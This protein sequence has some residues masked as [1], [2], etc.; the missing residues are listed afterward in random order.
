[1]ALSNKALKLTKGGTAI[2]NG[3][4]CALR[5]GSALSTDARGSS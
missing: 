5:S 2:R 4:S 3:P 1:V